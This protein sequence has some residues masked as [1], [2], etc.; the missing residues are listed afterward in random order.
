MSIRIQALVDVIQHK[1]ENIWTQLATTFFGFGICLH[2][3]GG[4]EPIYD[5]FSCFQIS[6]ILY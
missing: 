2:L 3:Y 1:V 6:N 5:D 4:L